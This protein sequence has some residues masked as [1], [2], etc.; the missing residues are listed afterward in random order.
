MRE[1]T[2]DDDRLLPP[3]PATR[4]VAREIY[5]AVRDLPIVSMHGH[6]DAALLAQNLPFPDPASLLVVPDHYVTRML[7]SQGERSLD[8][9]CPATEPARSTREIWR[10]FCAGWHLFRGTPVAG[11]GWSTSWSRSSAS[12]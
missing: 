9:A 8:S 10:R 5:A 2:L 11:C 12:P 7:V 1:L 3:D 6:V 4:A